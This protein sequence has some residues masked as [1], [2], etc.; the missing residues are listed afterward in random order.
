MQ[1]PTE[2]ETISGDIAAPWTLSVGGSV[3]PCPKEGRWLAPTLRLSANARKALFRLDLADL[4]GLDGRAPVAIEQFVV[5]LDCPDGLQGPAGAPSGWSIFWIDQNWRYH[6]PGENGWDNLSCP[7]RFQKKLGPGCSDDTTAVGFYLSLNDSVDKDFVFQG[8]VRVSI[9]SLVL[10]ASARRRPALPEKGPVEESLAAETKWRADPSYGGSA[11]I[12]LYRDAA[13]LDCDLDATDLHKLS[14]VAGLRFPPR[15]MRTRGVFLT[16]EVPAALVSPSKLKSGMHAGVL[17]GE[18]VLWGPWL[19]LTT[20]G[21]VTVALYPETRFP[22][23]MSFRSAGFDASKADGIAFRVTVDQATETRFKGGIIIREAQ[24]VRAPERLIESSNAIARSLDERF[25]AGPVTNTEEAQVDIREFVGKIGV[26]YPWPLDGRG[27]GIYPVVPGRCWDSS[28][29][30]GGLEMIGETITKDFRMLAE[31]RVALVRVWIFGDF[32]RGLEKDGHGGLLLS[33]SCLADTRTL[34]AAAES[35]HIDLV[36]VLLD[37]SLADLQDRERLGLV[38]EEPAILTNPSLREQFLKSIRPVV[39][40][41]CASPSVRVIDLWNEP[42]QMSVPM[43]DVMET[44]VALAAMVDKRKPVTIGS[45]NSVDMLFWMRSGIVDVPTFHF[46]AKMEPRAYPKAW[47]PGGVR[48]NRTIATE[49]E[50]TG[51]VAATLTEMWEAGFCGALLWSMNA[52]DGITPFGPNEADEFQRWVERRVPAG[53]K[54]GRSTPV[55][56]AAVAP[57][58]AGKAMPTPPQAV[59]RTGGAEPDPLSGIRVR[60]E[61]PPA[62]LRPWQREDGPKPNHST[63]AEYA[64]VAIP[65]RVPCVTQE[66]VIREPA[67]KHVSAMQYLPI[68]P[69]RKWTYRR[70][71]LPYWGLRGKKGDVECVGYTYYWQSA[72]LLKGE[73]LD[74]RGKLT[75]ITD[76]HPIGS[77]LA[78]KPSVVDHVLILKNPVQWNGTQAYPLDASPQEGVRD[79]RYGDRDFSR[80]LWLER[81]GK[82]GAEFTEVLTWVT[83]P[84][85]NE[86]VETARPILFDAGFSRV[87]TYGPRDDPTRYVLRGMVVSA[88]T[89]K[90]SVPAGEFPDTLRAVEYLAARGVEEG[91]LSPGTKPDTEL[92]HGWV[93]VAWF[94]PGVGLVKEIQYTRS[95]RLCY[96]LELIST[97]V[98]AGQ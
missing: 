93:T 50:A 18:E 43:D 70:T 89:D 39:D 3:L 2:E 1:P 12:T 6:E 84:S 48:R 38:G 9:D 66:S 87:L 49:V 36:P 31:H 24:V 21:P 75:V 16:V 32:R 64:W 94:A 30:E 78:P 73:F 69:G 15:D 63:I 5:T 56:S 45:R 82:A 40:M 86:T 57:Q 27:E 44:L 61:M 20:H 67:L 34:L 4:P 79:G 71:V 62:P 26:N 47:A 58:P 51:G 97:S 35:V 8:V 29:K 68:E 54:A 42:C 37:F 13:Q 25:P 98:A 83:P 22:L 77:G 91:T 85:P 14:A 65:P 53:D 60:L 41:L 88:C 80:T 23:P 95:G 11:G 19:P 46:F 52:K 92:N 76:T 33:P 55:T 81:Q 90:I 74:T 10:R 7:G 28:G 17:C 96:V 72:H 59:G